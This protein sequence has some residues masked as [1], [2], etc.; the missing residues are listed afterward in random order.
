[1]PGENPVCQRSLAHATFVNSFSHSQKLVIVQRKLR[2]DASN[3]LAPPNADI[4]VEVR[5]IW[6]PWLKSKCNFAVRY[7]IPDRTNIIKI[8]E[9]RKQFSCEVRF[10][11]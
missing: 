7:V 5:E 1:M 2:H 8:M 10:P 4:D 9:Q 3:L 6:Q 11:I